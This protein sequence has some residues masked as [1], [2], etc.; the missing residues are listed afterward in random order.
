MWPRFGITVGTL[1]VIGI[2]IIDSIKENKMIFI[3]YKYII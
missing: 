2:L 1:K 3:E